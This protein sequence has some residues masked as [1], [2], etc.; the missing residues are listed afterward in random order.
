MR[1]SYIRNTIFRIRDLILPKT[2]GQESWDYIGK[3]IESDMPFMAARLGAVEVKAVL[4]AKKPWLSP[5]LQQY[6]RINMPRNAGFFPISKHSLN[7]FANMMTSD[8]QQVDVL[9]SWRPEEIFLRKELKSAYKAA[10][11]DTNIHPE[12]DTFW[13][14]YLAG[15]KVLVIHPFTSTIEKQYKENRTK[16]F[17]R[18]DFIPEF[19]SLS[20]I[21]AVQSIAGNHAGF[22]TWFEALDHMKSET[23]KA[24]FDIALIG[25]GAYGFPLAA[26]IKRM[27]KQAIHLGGVLQLY[28]G[29]KGKRWNDWG[30]YNDYWVSPGTKEIPKGAEHVEDGCY[31]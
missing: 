6:V 21:Q 13:T 12:E 27:G 10:F 24:D 17:S 23:E 15:K 16:L 25:C 4:Y 8:M 1:N 22:D 11:S 31:W 30:L 2:C 19:A 28:F 3:C 7:Q 9:F 29:I 26:H 14:R 20:T 18:P 5:F